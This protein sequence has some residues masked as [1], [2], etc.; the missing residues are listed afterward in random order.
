MDRYRQ[1]HVMSDVP[2]VAVGAAGHTRVWEGT[3]IEAQALHESALLVEQPITLRHCMILS[4]GCDLVKSRFPLATVAPVYDAS[5]LLSEDQKR[6]A[7]SGSMVH[8]VHLEADWAEPGFWVADLRMEY[9]VEK[10]ILA[11]R[12]PLPAFA[13]EE[14]YPR[15]AERLATMRVRAA[16]PDSCLQLVVGPMFNAIRRIEED[17]GA[18]LRQGVR[19]F[20]IQF[21]HPSNPATTTVFVLGDKSSVFSDRQLE[22][23]DQVYAEVQPGCDAAGL[24]LLGIDP[25]SLDD[26]TAFDYLTSYPVRDASSS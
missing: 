12:D 23:F 21:D 20:R 19:E 18:D 16:V 26:L 4:Q 8:L 9:A 15:L 5:G 17:G 13:N 25:V 2:V 7:R 10:T 6:S 24:N 14:G 22:Q 1:G 3:T 11:A